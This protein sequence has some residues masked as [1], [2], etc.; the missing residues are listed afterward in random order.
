MNFA[1]EM[2]K[3]TID[4]VVRRVADMIS[5]LFKEIDELIN[6]TAERGLFD[7]VVRFY[8]S[9]TAEDV[10]TGEYDDEKKAYIVRGLSELLNQQIAANLCS[11]HYR[12]EGFMTASNCV[13]AYNGSQYTTCEISWRKLNNTES[14]KGTNE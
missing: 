9:N 6:D 13:T 14:N 11:W 7:I 8:N 4:V 10:F 2:R 5:P 3:K 1:E 12:D